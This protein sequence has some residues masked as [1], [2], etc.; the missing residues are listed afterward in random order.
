MLV[1][2]QVIAR[3]AV[4]EAIL[5]QVMGSKHEAFLYSLTLLFVSAKKVDEVKL[6]MARE[7]MDV[8]TLLKVGGLKRVGGPCSL[9]IAQV[10][11]ENTVDEAIPL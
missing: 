5:L 9:A 4:D 3:R 10:I 11:A 8:V 6:L 2:V 1:H 7:A